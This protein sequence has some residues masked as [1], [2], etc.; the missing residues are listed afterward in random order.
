[1]GMRVAR[2]LGV[3]VGWRGAKGQLAPDLW[4]QSEFGQHHL[5]LGLYG[6]HVRSESWLGGRER[7]QNH[8]CRT[9]PCHSQ[10]MDYPGNS[11]QEGK[12]MLVKLSGNIQSY[13]GVAVAFFSP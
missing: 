9:P 13:N 1:M 11:L 6:C 8:E 4:L 5:C 12:W 3:I 7:Q 2:E 10:G